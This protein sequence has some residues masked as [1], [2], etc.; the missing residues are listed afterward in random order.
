[1]KRVAFIPFI[2]TFPHLQKPEKKT[3]LLFESGARIHTTEFEWPKSSAP[4][5]FSMKLRYDH[6]TR[7][8]HWDTWAKTK[9]YK[10][11]LK[12]L[13]TPR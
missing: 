3:M 13:F 1:M 5:G 9:N 12:C 10:H 8:K 2:V 7:P 11:P 6:K 4:S